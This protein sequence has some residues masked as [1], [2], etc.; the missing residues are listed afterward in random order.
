M[1]IFYHAGFGQILQFQPSRTISDR[2]Y[3]AFRV[4]YQSW[5]RFQVH[6]WRI[7]YPFLALR[8]DVE[9]CSMTA[10]G[11][12]TTDALEIYCNCIKGCI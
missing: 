6:A 1:K 10:A 12:R 4:D 8:P 2:I 3:I 5:V 11:L 9:L 7:R